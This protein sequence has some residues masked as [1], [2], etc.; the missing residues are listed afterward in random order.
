MYNPWDLAGPASDELSDVI[1]SKATCNKPSI[2]NTRY[3]ISVSVSILTN[4]FLKINVE[5]LTP[6]NV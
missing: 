1:T 4:N 2:Q 3:N 5:L 6:P